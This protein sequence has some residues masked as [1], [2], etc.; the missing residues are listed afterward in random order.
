MNVL[1]RATQ[2]TTKLA[3][4]A[5]D[6]MTTSKL[7]GVSSQSTNKKDKKGLPFNATHNHKESHNTD[8]KRVRKNEKYH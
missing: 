8:C 5:A 1:Q 2:S 3:Q 6:N 7:S 4:R